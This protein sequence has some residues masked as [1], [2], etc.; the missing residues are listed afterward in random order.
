MGCERWRL[1]RVWKE[2]RRNARGET[3]VVLVW[4]QPLALSSVFSWSLVGVRDL[5]EPTRK[6]ADRCQDRHRRQNPR[7]RRCS[8]FD[9]QVEL[10]PR[11]KLWLAVELAWRGP[12]ERRL[13][14]CGR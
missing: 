12:L 14:S 5:H 10:V 2:V 6:I 9:L 13:L 1:S 8:S 7:G 3:V 11:L 4:A